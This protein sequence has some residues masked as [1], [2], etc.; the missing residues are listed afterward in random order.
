MRRSPRISL[1]RDLPLAGAPRYSRGKIHGLC[2]YLF[3]GGSL[4][5]SFPRR[6]TAVLAPALLLAGAAG[7]P[8]A[9]A[10]ATRGATCPS[11][12]VSGDTV[13]FRSLAAHA[14]Y[15]DSDH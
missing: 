8:P 15:L 4:V 5:P 14:T 6:L 2:G 1:F 11:P 12:I 10:A 13:L 9:A 7:T 3:S